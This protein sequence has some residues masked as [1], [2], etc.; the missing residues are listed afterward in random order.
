MHCI[1]SS[2]MSINWQGSNTPSFSPSRGIRQGDPLSPYLIVLCMERLSH[3]IQDSLDCSDWKPFSCN[4]GGPKISHLFAD[5]LLLTG[6]ASMQQMEV[7]KVVLDRFCSHSGS[8]DQFSQA[9]Y[10]LLQECLVSPS[11]GHE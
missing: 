2:T 1:S 9:R 7:V 3:C 8:E 4:R 6:E 10:L 11:T 5:D